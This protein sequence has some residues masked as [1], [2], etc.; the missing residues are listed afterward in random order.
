MCKHTFCLTCERL[1]R[2]PWNQLHESHIRHSVIAG[3]K[4]DKKIEGDMK[5]HVSVLESEKSAKAMLD[6]EERHN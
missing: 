3:D 6:G 2:G 5:R 4:D 1:S